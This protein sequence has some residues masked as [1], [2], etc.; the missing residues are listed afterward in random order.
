MN[1]DKSSSGK[2][3]VPN[4]PSFVLPLI[5]TEIVDVELVRAFFLYITYSFEYLL[6]MAKV[7][8]SDIVLDT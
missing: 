5:P 7:C 2:I 8:A 4:I 3:A 1:P 6:I